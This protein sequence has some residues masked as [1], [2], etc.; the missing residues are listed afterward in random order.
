MRYLPLV[1]AA[2]LANP[3]VAASQ[4]DTLTRA[5][6]SCGA[7]CEAGESASNPSI[8]LGVE[9][10]G[11]TAD[12]M[13]GIPRDLLTAEAESILRDFG[14]AIRP[15][16]GRINGGSIQ[17]HATALEQDGGR[18]CAASLHLVFY[19]TR[20]MPGSEGR[21]PYYAGI[22]VDVSPLVT[23]VHPAST[24]R[25][26]LR[27]LVNEQVTAWANNLA[28][29]RDVFASVATDAAELPELAGP[30]FDTAP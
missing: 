24:H 29:A 25:D 9:V 11:T 17:I 8:G 12:G 23:L 3:V 28:R 4:L 1:V 27:R 21:D 19:I 26:V 16:S 13:C 20:L 2:C 6:T 14:F 22:V 10:I 5:A 30:T 15:G 7:W 18:W